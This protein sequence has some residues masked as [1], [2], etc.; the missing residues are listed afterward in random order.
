MCP[1]GMNRKAV[2][3]RGDNSL[4]V[5]DVDDEAGNCV[6]GVKLRDWAVENGKSGNIEAFKKDLADEFVGRAGDA[7][8]N[9]KQDRR[10]VL[11]T[12]ETEAGEEDMFPECSIS[13]TNDRKIAC[14]ESRVMKMRIDTRVLPP[15]SSQKLYRP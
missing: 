13:I 6:G 7:R 11:D 5:V 9:G 10:F 3:D 8:E 14:I 4:I 1:R 12:T 2:C 15:V